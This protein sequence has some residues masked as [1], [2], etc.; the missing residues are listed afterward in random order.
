[1]LNVQRLTVSLPNYLYQLLASRVENGKMSQF[2]TAVL[3]KELIAKE[4]SNPIGDFFSLRQRLPKK[5]YKDIIKAIKTGR[6]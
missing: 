5:T 6:V 3:E 2:V 4:K 1:M